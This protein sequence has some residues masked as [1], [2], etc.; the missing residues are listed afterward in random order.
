MGFPK[1]VYKRGTGRKVDDSGL[2]TA[3]FEVVRSEEELAALGSGWCDSPVDAGVAAQLELK[4]DE[5]P[6]KKV[7]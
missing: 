4:H 6:A 1:H 5:K 2:F 3:E 7:K